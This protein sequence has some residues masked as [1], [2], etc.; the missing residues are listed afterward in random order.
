[1]GFSV[2]VHAQDWVLVAIGNEGVVR[3]IARK[4]GKDRSPR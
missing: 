1:M 2:V 4:R 3:I